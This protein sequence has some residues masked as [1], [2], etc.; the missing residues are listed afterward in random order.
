MVGHVQTLDKVHTHAN[1]CQDSLALIVRYQCKI[2]ALTPVSTMEHAKSRSNMQQGI[3]VIVDVD[4][5]VNTVRKKQLH[6][7]QILARI[8]VHVTIKKM[9]S[10][11][12]VSLA[13][14]EKTVSLRLKTVILTLA[15]TTAVA[16]LLEAVIMNVTVQKDLQEHIV[17]KISMI[18][19]GI[20]VK[21]E[22]YALM[23][24]TNFNAPV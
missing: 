21:T 22:V 18:V 17:R 14:V 4:G 9:V 6:V 15:P 8:M 20:L 2:V 1:A 13:L 23:V 3:N 19:M 7:L 10:N 12:N 11:A 5:P 24:L 16:L